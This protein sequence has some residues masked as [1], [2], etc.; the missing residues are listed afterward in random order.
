MITIIGVTAS[1]CKPCK[2][3]MPLIREE[4][5]KLGLP[6]SIR[7][8]AVEVDFANAHGVKS[9]PTLLVFKDGELFN[10]VS[11]VKPAHELSEFLA[12]HI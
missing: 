10:R 12:E 5:A 6:F 2:S 8:A 7:D 11:G 4:C 9:A 1:W 3:F